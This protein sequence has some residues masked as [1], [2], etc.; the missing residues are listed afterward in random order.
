M[1]IRAQQDTLLQ[2][3]I[4]VVIIAVFVV[5]GLGWRNCHRRGGTYV[6]GLFRMECIR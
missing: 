1:R 6:Q 3:A 4:V 5:L 2:F